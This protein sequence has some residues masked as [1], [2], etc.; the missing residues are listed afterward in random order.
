MIIQ[1]DGR[2]NLAELVS[3]GESN[4]IVAIPIFITYTEPDLVFKEVTVTPG[5]AGSGS[6]V[7]VSWTV[8]N[9]GN[10]DT[11]QSHLNK[12]GS[13]RPMGDGQSSWSDSVYL[14]RDDTIDASDQS[15]SVSR[16]GVLQVGESY[17][18]TAQL[19]IPIDAEGTYYVLIA[20]DGG[21]GILEFAREFNNFGGTPFTVVLTPPPDLQ[22]SQ[23]VAPDTLQTSQRGHV[24]WTV[25]NAGTGPT[26]VS[27]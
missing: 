11:R 16:S 24:D 8:A 13:P 20:A 12:D 14:S 15:F 4:N 1:T 21:N 23:V 7:T 5:Q 9:E 26:A 25:V 3:G 6:E 17:T 18:Q 2:N 22:V 27:Q 19:K 10:R